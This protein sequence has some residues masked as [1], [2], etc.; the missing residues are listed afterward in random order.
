M[1]I[2]DKNVKTQIWETVG[3]ECFRAVAPA[4]YRGAVGALVVYDITPSQRFG[5]LSVKNA[6]ALSLP[7]ITVEPSEHSS[8]MTSLHLNG[9]WLDDLNSGFFSLFDA[10]FKQI[11]S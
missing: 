4:Y 6:S 5:R 11:E 2:D 10:K 7:P 8:F 1:L 3:Q 9:R